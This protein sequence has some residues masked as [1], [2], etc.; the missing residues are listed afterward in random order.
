ME[1][2]AYTVDEA[3]TALGV[4]RDMIYNLMREG[5]LRYVQAADRKRLIPADAMAEFLNGVAS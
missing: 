1:R 4:S 2:L 3:R 5:R